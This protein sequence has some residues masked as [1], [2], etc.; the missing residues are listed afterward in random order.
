MAV[1]TAFFPTLSQ[2]TA[3]GKW[4][5]FKEFGAGDQS[6][7]LYYDPLRD[8]FYHYAPGDYPVAF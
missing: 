6:D 1:S 3:V 4:E 2:L 5:E 7:P 8:W